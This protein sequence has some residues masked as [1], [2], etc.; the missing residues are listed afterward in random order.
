MH[1]RLL[2]T[3]EWRR[4]LATALDTKE[5]DGQVVAPQGASATAVEGKEED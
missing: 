3:P 2:K 4:F 5:I 1:I